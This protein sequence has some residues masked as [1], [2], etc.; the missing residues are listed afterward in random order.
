[1][2][3]VASQ[4]PSDYTGDQKK[5]ALG[6]LLRRA[7]LQTQVDKGDKQL[8]TKQQAEIDSINE[9]LKQISEET[10]TPT[11][12]E[13]TTE[14]AIEALEAEDAIREKMTGK[15]S[16]T[17]RTRAVI[18]K[19]RQELNK[20]RQD[21]I[22]ESSTTEVDV[23]E[24]ATDGEAVGSG[25]PDGGTAEDGTQETTDVTGE[26][27]SESEEVAILE[28]LFGS[29]TGKT[30]GEGETQGTETKGEEDY[31]GRGKD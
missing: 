6:L 3:G 21:A 28:S 30:K 18:E 24:Q 27:T 16:A 17:A 11:I 8:V 13:A 25:D 23:Q 1:M 26:D 9:S 2:A 19:K 22:Q 12:T 31:R 29:E 7:K 5:K 15:P 20:Q 14:E 10:T 4:I